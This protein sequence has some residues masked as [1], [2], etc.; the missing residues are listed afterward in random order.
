MSARET[1]QVDELISD[2][3]E[4]YKEAESE[5]EELLGVRAISSEEATSYQRTMSG[6]EEEQKYFESSDSDETSQE[7]QSE[8]GP[9]K[10]SEENLNEEDAAYDETVYEQPFN[11]YN[12]ED[13]DKEEEESSHNATMAQN[14]PSKE[15]IVAGLKLK[16]RAAPTTANVAKQAL[17]LME[18]RSTYG[19]DKLS[20]LFEAIGK[21]QKNKFGLLTLALEDQDK[22]EDTRLSVQ[23]TQQLTNDGC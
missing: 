9:N 21:A 2:I 13:Q 19:A 10:S 12:D 11:A 4:E 7:P 22:L 15:V 5:L 17:F 16:I 14:Q 8:E 3:E 18:Q 6:G 20:S 1:D 23:P